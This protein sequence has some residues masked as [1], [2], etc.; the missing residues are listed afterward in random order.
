MGVVVDG[1][2]VLEFVPFAPGPE[3]ESG[4]RNMN[5]IGIRSLEPAPL[6]DPDPDHV[7]VSA[8]SWGKGVMRFSIDTEGDFDEA[9]LELLVADL[10]RLGIGEEHFVSGIT[11]AGT[12]LKGEIVKQGERERYPVLWHDPQ[13]GRW[14]HMYEGGPSVANP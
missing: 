6:P 9:V 4:L 7:A 13:D 1:R 8:G 11:Y 2:P 3:S 10:T 12:R 14:R 5:R